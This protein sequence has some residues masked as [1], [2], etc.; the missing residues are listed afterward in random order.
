MAAVN[1]TR[2]VQFL[3]EQDGMPQVRLSR[4]IVVQDR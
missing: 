4:A 2:V 1:Q 3:R